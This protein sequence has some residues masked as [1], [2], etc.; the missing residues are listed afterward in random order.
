MND[1]DLFLIFFSSN[2]TR[3]ILDLEFHSSQTFPAHLNPKSLKAVLTKYSCIPGTCTAATQLTGL[4][5]MSSVWVCA[6]RAHPWRGGYHRSNILKAFVCAML[7]S[8]TLQTPHARD[9][10]WG[11]PCFLTIFKKTIFTSSSFPSPSRCCLC[12][13]TQKIEKN[14]DEQWMGDFPSMFGESSAPFLM[15][16]LHTLKHMHSWLDHNFS[17]I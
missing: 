9:I 8:G 1:I 3:R 7:L 14:I 17:L 5:C 4:H 12:N 2:I 11:K 13:I 15:I 16:Q 10:F 6:V